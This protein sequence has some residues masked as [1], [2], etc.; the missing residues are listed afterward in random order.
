MNLVAVLA[1]QAPLEQDPQ[2][3]GTGFPKKIRFNLIAS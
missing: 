2:K 1:A 3:V